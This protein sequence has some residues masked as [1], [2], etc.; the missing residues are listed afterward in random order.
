MIYL[1]MEQAW[2]DG[3][4]PSWIYYQMNG[5]SAYENYMEQKQ[6]MCEKLLANDYMGMDVNLKSK[7]EVKK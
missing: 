4:V 6:A 7:I 3:K 5:K 2:R 1:N